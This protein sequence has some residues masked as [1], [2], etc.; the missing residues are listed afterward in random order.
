MADHHVEMRIHKRELE[1]NPTVKARRQ[2]ELFLRAAHEQWLTDGCAIKYQE[3]T[4]RDVL[5]LRISI[6]PRTVSPR[7]IFNED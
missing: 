7:L 5:I 6:T 3:R 4:E 2:S 1:E